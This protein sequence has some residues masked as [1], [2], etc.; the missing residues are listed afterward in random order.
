MILKMKLK[1]VLKKLKQIMKLAKS[2]KLDQKN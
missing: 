1:E 2:M